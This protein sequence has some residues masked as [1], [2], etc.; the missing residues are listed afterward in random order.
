MDG[1]EVK[2]LKVT[3]GLTKPLTHKEVLR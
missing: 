2:K 3:D 1:K